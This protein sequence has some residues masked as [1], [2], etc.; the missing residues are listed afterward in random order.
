MGIV[1]LLWKKWVGDSESQHHS[2][3]RQGDAFLRTRRVQQVCWCWSCSIYATGD[4]NRVMIQSLVMIPRRR[5]VMKQHVGLGLLT[6]ILLHIGTTPGAPGASSAA[7]ATSLELSPD[8]VF[9]FVPGNL[10][11]DNQCKV[12]RLPSTGRLERGVRVALFFCSSRC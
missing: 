11:F 2:D 4:A 7:T 8:I 9:Q 12:A 10:G 6:R 1:N 3:A 5:I